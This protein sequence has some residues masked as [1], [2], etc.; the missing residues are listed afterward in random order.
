MSAAAVVTIVLVALGVAVIAAFLIALALM[1]RRVSRRL[2][3][4]SES[5]LAVAEGSQPAGPLLDRLTATLEDV[6]TSLE[7]QVTTRRP[8]RDGDSWPPDA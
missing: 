2:E 3:A 7:D 4:V 1:L 5:L 6:R 8:Q